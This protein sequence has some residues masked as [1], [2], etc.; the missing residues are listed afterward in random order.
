MDSEEQK[1]ID[2]IISKI[3]NEYGLEIKEFYTL[4]GALKVYEALK[5]QVA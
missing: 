5:G 1:Q 4:D 3:Y 2:I